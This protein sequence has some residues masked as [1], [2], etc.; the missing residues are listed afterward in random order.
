[1]A[2]VQRTTAMTLGVLFPV[3]KTR[4]LSI[5]RPPSFATSWAYLLLIVVSDSK[6][7]SSGLSELAWLE[8]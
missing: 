4:V 5:L 8:L 1:M 2:S 7:M 3:H 6:A